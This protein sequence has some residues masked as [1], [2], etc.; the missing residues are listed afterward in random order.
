M[1]LSQNYDVMQPYTVL[2]HF[3]KI[4]NVIKSLA[5]FLLGKNVTKEKY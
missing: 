3:F 5:V 1:K 4:N 2:Q